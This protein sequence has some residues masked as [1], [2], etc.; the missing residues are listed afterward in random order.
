MRLP[1]MIFGG[2]PG[3]PKNQYSQNKMANFDP[4]VGIVWD[5]KGDGRMSI[6]AGYGIFYDFPSFAFDQFG[7][8]PPWGANLT[9]TNPASLVI[10]GVI[11]RAGI[12]SRWAPP[13]L[14]SSHRAMRS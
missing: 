10:P 3:L 7:F 13:A 2:D 12:R 1:G 4:R 11:S 9:V 14:I 6:R 8:S 5:P